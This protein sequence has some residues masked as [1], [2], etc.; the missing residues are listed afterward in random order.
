MRFEEAT[1]EQ[2]ELDRLTVQ[3]IIEH[4]AQN[5]AT[6][7]YSELANAIEEMR[8]QSMAPL[9]TAHSL[10][11]IQK[12]CKEKDLP[13]LSVMVVSKEDG[14]PSKGF[15]EAY[16]DIYGNT[17]MSEEEIIRTEQEKCLNCSCWQPL[18]DRV[19]IH[20]AAPKMS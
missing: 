5:K 2:Q 9:G 15:F 10:G 8:D 3:A 6:I 7:T 18:Y 16:Y 14:K 20:A 4:M 12:Y 17:E 11:R 13:I 1:P 19:S